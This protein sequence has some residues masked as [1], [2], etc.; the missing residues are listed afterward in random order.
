MVIVVHG[1]AGRWDDVAEAE[2]RA[3]CERSAREGWRVLEAGGA[4]IDAVE[5]AV[6]VLEE[7]PLYNSGRGACFTREGTIELDAAIMDGATLRVGAVG[8]VPPVASAVRLA[9]KVL[10]AN[11]AVFLVGAGAARF[12]EECGVGVVS[13]ESLE[14]E[15]ARRELAA[16]R[17]EKRGVTTEA[18]RA[19][20]SEEEKK[21]VRKEQ[22]EAGAGEDAGA[23]AEKRGGTV[24]AVAVDARGNVAAATSTGGRAGKRSGRVG[25]T[26][27]AGA[28]TYADNELGAAS[29]TG[30]GEYIIRA[31][32]TRSAVERFRGGASAMAAAREALARMRD[33]TGGVGGII[34][35][36]PRGDVGVAHT[37]PRMPYAIGRDGAVVSGFSVVPSYTS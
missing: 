10:E 22:A 33:R 25:D 12:A 4:A 34:V 6:R 5:A 16:E 24:G 1:G 14:T 26:P 31:G 8:A 23:G 35:V 32:L 11:E 15:R 20:R 3:G 21:G 29:A 27:I 17:E 30:P 36:T 37:T 18:Q 7:D 28:G 19:Q 9:R 2:A 13:Q